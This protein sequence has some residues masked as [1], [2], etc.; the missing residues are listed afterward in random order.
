MG[1][2]FWNELN[3]SNGTVTNWRNLVDVSGTNITAV[4]IKVTARD[5]FNAAG[6]QGLPLSSI[7]DGLLGDYIYVGPGSFTV[8]LSGLD[9]GS[10]YSLVV[11]CIGGSPGQAA[12]ASGAVSGTTTATIADGYVLENNYLFNS[13]AIPNAAGI[14]QFQLKNTP[15]NNFAAFNGLQLRRN[16]KVRLTVER[17]DSGRQQLNWSQGMLLEAEKVN[18]PWAT[19][20]AAAPP[21]TLSPTAGQRFFQI[22]VQ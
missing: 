11:Y 5:S 12:I 19:N 14:L 20:G 13:N 2:G 4:S 9:S 15:Q 18:G 16:P 17:G 8:T 10:S 22:L 3:P 21:F 6:N 1:G 7:T